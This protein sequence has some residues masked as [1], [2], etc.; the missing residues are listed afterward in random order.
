MRLESITHKEIERKLKELG[1]TFC[2]NYK[3]KILIEDYLLKDILKEKLK[4]INRQTFETYNLKTEQIT[5][6]VDNTINKLI[7]IKD[8]VEVLDLLKKGT[9]VEVDRG[10]KGN[11]TLHIKFFD[12]ENSQNNHFCYIYE[13]KF[14]GQPENIEPDF[15]LFMNGIPVVVI[16]AKKEVSEVETHKEGITQVERYE[17]EAPELFKYVQLAVVVADEDVY[18]ATYPNYEMGLRKNRK[19]NIWKDENGNSNIWELLTPRILLDVIENFIFFNVNRA[20]NLTKV[21]PRY[22]QYKAVKKAFERVK[23]YLEESGEKNRGLIWHWQGSGKTYEI[24]YLTENFY[25]H[26]RSRN[27]IV[28]IVIDRKEL[29]EQFEKDIEP[30]KNAEF[31]EGYKKIESVEALKEILIKIKE[32][33]EKAQI[34]PKGVYLVMAHKFRKEV[35]Q[36]LE[37]IGIIQKREVLILR[38][39]AH[40]TES[41]I[42]ASVRKFVMP[43]AIAFGFTGTPVHK[44]ESIST[45]KEYGYPSEGE[46]YLDKYFIEQSIKDGFTL[47]LMWRVALSEGVGLTLSEKQ[48]EELIRNY[49]LDRTLERDEEETEELPEISEEEVKRK[50]IFSDLLQAE[51]FIKKAS[52]YIAKRILEDTENFTFKA[53]IIAQDRKSTILFKKYLDKFIP[54]YVKNYNPEWSQVIIT[55]QHNEK[56]DIIREYK[57]EIERKHKKSV[58]E[59]NK[60]WAEKFATSENPKILIINKK[61]LT[62]F[63]APVLKVI[64]VAQ[65]LKDALLHQASARAN[66]PTIGKQYGLIVDL[67]GVLIENYKK[68][69]RKYNLYEDETINEDI[70]K[71]LFIES[72]KIW[73][74][75]LKK[76]K[77]FEELFKKITGLEIETFI[78]TLKEIQEV[79]EFFSDVINKIITT[80]N[81]FYKLY[82]L[83][84]ELIKLYESIGAYSEKVKYD[85]IYKGLKILYA[86]ISK[87][88][89]PKQTV[90][91]S[92]ELEAE[93]LKRLTFKE[94][95]DIAELELSEEVIENFRKNGRLYVVV[96]DFIFPVINYLEDKRD[97]IYKVIYKRLVKL[98]NDYLSRKKVVEEVVKLLKISIEE[99]K[100]YEIYKRGSKPEDL[101]FKNI[102]FFVKTQGGVLVDKESV[103]ESLKEFLKRKLITEEM[104]DR[105]KEVFIISLD[106]KNKNV[107][108]FSDTI[109][110]D[111]VIP[112]AKEL[113]KW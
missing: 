80:E 105:L 14:K 53:M 60:K 33:E 22:M 36:E 70:L 31:K 111:I 48:I 69:I 35:A 84:K 32:S 98:K 42:F 92:Q 17:R 107:E 99:I 78:Q 19:I 2:V 40:R 26:Y 56:I 52:E 62:G 65:L 100:N 37:K 86:G 7:T 13:A 91:I 67:C 97:P 1:W 102:E 72:S 113:K 103:K 4:E 15:T 106:I 12:Y 73:D 47:P 28:F 81:G 58:E 6:I 89:K 38:D 27:P 71:N 96:A 63:D 10:R 61:L 101:I 24:L 20:G 79:K 110:N 87:K 29:E 75:F 3:V 44:K 88:I 21:I 34:T 16:E 25:K 85:S 74:T 104:K 30:L 39:E 50:L 76:L 45:F 90:K 59:L 18:F 54:Q 68:A 46:F 11:L 23:S 66:R 55:Y 5:K 64:Y 57:E 94:I 77:Q 82:P 43:N 83:L 8:P 49:F 51:D 108:T 95:K 109:I 112:M 93:L 41:G 9:L